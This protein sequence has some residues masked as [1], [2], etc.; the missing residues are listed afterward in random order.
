MLDDQIIVGRNQAVPAKLWDKEVEIG[1]LKRKKQF[2]NVGLHI[3]EIRFIYSELRNS[4]KRLCLFISA[5]ETI[6]NHVPEALAVGNLIAFGMS[7]PVARCRPQKQHSGLRGHGVNQ[8]GGERERARHI[9]ASRW[10][11]PT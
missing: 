4:G 11:E 2:A 5:Q 3:D 9:A 7:C 6:G 1:R 8:F 10:G